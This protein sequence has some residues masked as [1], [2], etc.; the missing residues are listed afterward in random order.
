[1]RRLAE[2]V[3]CALVVS[4]AVRKCEWSACSHRL[5]TNSRSV[6]GSHSHSGA[7]LRRLALQLLAHDTSHGL[8]QVFAR[9]YMA[10][11][12]VDKRLIAALAGAGLEVLDQSS[13]EHDGHPLLT[14]R[15]LEPDPKGR[16][17]EVDLGYLGILVPVVKC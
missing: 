2:G 11:R 13:V 8:L 6:A 7:R 1:M 5:T 16:P 15:G 12:V 9:H 4:V 10:Q 3:V 14:R 17:V